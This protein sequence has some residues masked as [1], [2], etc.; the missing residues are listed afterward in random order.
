MMT[1]EEERIEQ[2]YKKLLDEYLEPDLVSLFQNQKNEELLESTFDP[3]M[4]SKVINE[5]LNK[6]CGCGR[7]CQAQ[8]STQEL[9]ES[10][11]SFRFLSLSEKN[12]YILA[13]LRLLSRHAEHATSAR[14]QSARQRQKF[15][16]RINIDR[17]ICRNMFLFYHGETIK[18]LKRLQ[19]CCA[20]NP[21]LPPVHGNKG[22]KPTNAYSQ[23]DKE[24]VKLFITNLAEIHGLPDP[25]RDVRKGKGRLRILLPSIM[26]YTGVHK[27]YERSVTEFGRIAVGY[28]TFLELWQNELPYIEFNKP[29]SDLCITCENFKKEI[30]QLTANMDDNKEEMQIILHKEAI[31]HLNFA[32][33]ERLYY[34]AHSQVSA[35]DYK[36]VQLECPRENFPFKA[37]SKDIVMSYSWDFAQ[38]VTYPFEDQQVGPIY[39]KTP[40][41]AQLFGVCCEGSTSQINYL[42]DEADFL[43]KNA[44]TV[45]SL[46]DHFFTNHGLGEMS[47]YL[48]A[49]NCIGQNKNNALIQYL[50]YRVLSN[51]HSRIEMSFLVVGHTKFSPDSHFGLIK[52]QYRNSAVYTYEQLAK[53]IEESA[54]SPYNVCQRYLGNIASA[55]IVYRDWST[56]L[57]TYFRSIPNITSYQHFKIDSKKRGIVLAKKEM[58]SEEEP[59]NLLKSKHPF[60]EEDT[61]KLPIQLFP[62]GLSV[63]RQWYLYDHIRE[64]IPSEIDKNSTC[65]KPV[66]P[67]PKNEQKKIA[68]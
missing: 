31:N 62:E 32:K 53:I 10:R 28:R 66:H 59:I 25:G 1:A 13:Q 37:N 47:A 12:C 21:M 29:R 5:F 19:E 41:R 49:D 18:R 40:R 60:D 43:E 9:L 67:K 57:S 22:T 4:E 54:E 35:S 51:L 23:S 64:H 46:L 52:Q 61:K 26:N 16:Y 27:L 7:N 14:S 55:G 30:N 50:M 3:L 34:K 20:E 58:D 17:P 44:N 65:P 38:Q 48:T 68:T 11:G 63:E 15:E 45:I 8:F 36:K 42:I 39:F 6:G 2:S 56:W 33:K 24:Y